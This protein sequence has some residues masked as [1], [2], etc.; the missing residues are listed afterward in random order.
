M[1]DTLLTADPV[2]AGTSVF[3][4]FSHKRWVDPPCTAVW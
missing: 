3:K 2:T 4:P 1:S